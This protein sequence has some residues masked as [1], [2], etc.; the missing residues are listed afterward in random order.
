[1]KSFLVS[2]LLLTAFG[3]TPAL[4]DTQL[5]EP[6]TDRAF[7]SDNDPIKSILVI[8]LPDDPDNRKNLEQTISKQLSKSGVE[9]VPSVDIMSMDTE[10]NEQSVRAA[11]AGKNIE[12]VLLTHVF[13]IDKDVETVPTGDTGTL[14][15][16]RSFALGLWG[17][18]TKARDQQLDAR[19][20]SGQRI[21]LEN[22]LYDINTAKMVWSAQSYSL[23]PKSVN[24]E[25]KSLGEQVAESL[26]KA[27]LI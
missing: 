12:A 17:D 20:D 10:V 24:K 19:R 3:A 26:R 18:Y 11:I 13:R 2:I 27:S 5:L 4:S 25:I 22:N 6:W 8:G 14:R 7:I 23:E 1:M 21:V 15:S 16:D 9:A